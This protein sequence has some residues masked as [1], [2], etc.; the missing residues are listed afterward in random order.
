MRDANGWPVICR[1]SDGGGTTTVSNSDPWSGQ[2]PYLQQG[3]A[4][5]QQN[6]LQRPLSYYPNSTVV[7][8]SEETTAGLDA[9]ANRALSGSPLVNNAQNYTN[10]I[11][12][13]PG[14]TAIY[15]TIKADVLPSIQ[16][17]FSGA[18][19]TGG[20]PLQA[21]AVGRGL[22]RGIAPY[23]EAAAARAPGLAREDYFDIGQLRDV[24]AARE[25][26]AQEN[27]QDSIAR[28]NFKQDEPANRL[29]RYMQLI[30]GNYGGTTTQSERS[31]INPYTTGAGLAAT[32]AQIYSG[33]N[34]GGK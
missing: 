7:P 14:G 10:D 6:V 16:G 30:Q 24:G 23:Q 28:F 29:G 2:Q 4:Q 12:T 8:F 21:E 13:N 27:L 31:Q 20:S 17:S 33:Y 19:R 32:G 11:L 9:Q 22:A 34:G 1:G 25:M 26:K 3:F 5:A 18:G 15:D